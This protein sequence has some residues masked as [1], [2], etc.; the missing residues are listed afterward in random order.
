MK[1]G[2]IV[3]RVTSDGAPV[4]AFMKVRGFLDNDHVLVQRCEPDMVV[5][6]LHSHYCLKKRL[7]VSK[8]VKFPIQD[9][10][11]ERI[12][13]GRQI[14]IIHDPTPLWEKMFDKEPE[15]VE[16][17]SVKY[18]QIKRM[19]FVVDRVGQCWYN[20][21]RQIRLTLGARIV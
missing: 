10:I 2:D 14:A 20:R 19:V 15:L 18:P 12:H 3:R 9:S 17:R 11:W 7:R 1:K 8:I 6:N 13:D 21:T 4:G 5:S 16:I